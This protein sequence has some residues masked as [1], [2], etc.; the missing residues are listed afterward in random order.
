MTLIVTALGSV[1]WI[2]TRQVLV[3]SATFSAGMQW[4]CGACNTTKGDREFSFAFP[5]AAAAPFK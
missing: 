1:N 4:L 5:A 3:S 2:N